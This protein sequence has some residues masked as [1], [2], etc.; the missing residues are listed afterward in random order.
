MRLLSNPVVLFLMFLIAAAQCSLAAPLCAGLSESEQ[1]R[2]TQYVAQKYAIPSTVKLTVK[3][4][5]AVS[6]DCHRKVVFCWTGAFGRGVPCALSVAGFTVFN[7]RSYG[8]DA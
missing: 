4:V 7:Q 6:D 2:L 5:E 3:Q 8:F 1:S